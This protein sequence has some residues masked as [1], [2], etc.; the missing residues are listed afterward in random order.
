MH[1]KAVWM[2][3]KE[4]KGVLSEFY[5]EDTRVQEGAGGGKALMNFM[6]GHFPEFQRLDNS[7]LKR[8]WGLPASA[9]QC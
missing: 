9:A 8:W 7:E 1:L 3:S 4:F 2:L 5:C 6:E